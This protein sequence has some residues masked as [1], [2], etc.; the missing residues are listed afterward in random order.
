LSSR[1]IEIDIWPI[2]VKYT[3]YIRFFF[4]DMPRYNTS[5]SSSCGHTSLT[6]NPSTHAS[7][8]GYARPTARQRAAAASG[9]P[10]AAGEKKNGAQDVSPTSF[11]APLIL[12]GD[13]L[14]LDPSESQQSF[15][16]WLDGEHRNKVTS[17]NKTVYVAAYPSVDDDVKFLHSWSRVGGNKKKSN[18]HSPRIEDV[19]GYL[20]AFYHGLP[21]KLLPSKLGFT[22]WD[23]TAASSKTK[24]KPATTAPRYIGLNIQTE[25]V[26]IRTRPSADNVFPGQLNLDDLLDAAISMLPDDAYALVMLTEYD[27][28][29]DDDDIFVC[30]RAYGG[31]R[32]A[33]VSTARYHPDLD[34][35]QDVERQHAWPA[36]HC[37]A[38]MKAC[39]AESSKTVAQNPKKRARDADAPSQGDQAVIHPLRAAVSTHEALPSLLEAPPSAAAA[40]LSGLWLGRVCRTASH[41]LGHCF[42]V[43]HC[44]YYACA[45]Q[46]SASL[47][48]DARQPPYL[49]PIDLLKILHAT[50]T[51][52]EHHY[53]ALLS[54][55]DQHE[56][57]HLFS[58]FGAWLRARLEH[59]RLTALG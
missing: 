39:C 40:T 21:V 53:L 51:T 35:E 46:G 22:S 25:C 2:S 42:G 12:P 13:D 47:T 19:V 18:V 59:M 44:P 7:K 20:T 28:Y 23:G 54:F 1:E 36:S 45:M 16:E 9:K 29:E 37:E 52:E 30:G 4:F 34:R 38:Y 26:R 41:E 8:A 17:E 55:C 14:A 11:P 48:E 24:S 56:E 49:C 43:G 15:Q 50:S 5:V 3:L 57:V 6:L 32:V 27:L 10:K 58:A 33:I 31:S